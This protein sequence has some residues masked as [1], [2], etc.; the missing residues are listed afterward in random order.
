[1]WLITKHA[2]VSVAAEPSSDKGWSRSGNR[3]DGFSRHDTRSVELVPRDTHLRRTVVGVR[4]FVVFTC[5][6][7]STLRPVAW[8]LFHVTNARGAPWTESGRS[9]LSRVD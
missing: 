7:K 9:S 6:L 4:S 8:N 2:A 1:M 3:L 5:G